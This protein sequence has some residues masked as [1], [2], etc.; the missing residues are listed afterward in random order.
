MQTPRMYDAGYFLFKKY[1]LDAK[2]KITMI[3]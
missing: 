3:F 2:R 1:G